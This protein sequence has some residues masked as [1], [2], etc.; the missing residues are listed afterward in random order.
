MRARPMLIIVSLLL[1]AR[2]ALAAELLVFDWDGPVSKAEHGF[3]WDKPPMAGVNGDWT[4]PHDFANGLLYHRVE[5]RSQ[6]VAQAMQLQFCF[7]QKGPERETCGDH[8]AVSGAPKTVVTWTQSIPAMWKKNN[9]P[10]DWTRAR[11]RNGVAIK[12]GSFQCV[13]DYANWN[14][15][16]NNP[17]QWY[18]LN[19]RFTVV[20]VTPQSTF[21]GWSNYITTAP[22]KDA[23]VDD[24]ALLGPDAGAED[25]PRDASG[26]E[27]SAAT[28]RGI[29]QDDRAPQD[30]SAISGPEAGASSQLSKSSG[31]ALAADVSN[32][33]WGLVVLLLVSLAG[34]MVLRRA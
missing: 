7:W 6:P 17:D 21:S 31:C 18:P 27:D 12:D 15:N 30:D 4:T 5:I 10:L 2:P 23:G 34:T 20:V 22:P 24:S 28:E 3:P 25:A 9:L 32:T 11:D 8:H 33:P 26:A 14:W 16:G 13:S 19:M 29:P 1:A